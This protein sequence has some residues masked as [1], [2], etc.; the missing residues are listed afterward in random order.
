MRHLLSPPKVMTFSATDPTGGAGLQADILTLASIYCH[1]ISIT[2]AITVQD[3]TGVELVSPVDSQLLKQQAMTIL[4]DVEVAV[5]KLGLLG[6]LENIKAI[7]EILETYPDIPVVLDPIIASGRGDVLMNDSM[8]KAMIRLIF[9]KTTL[10]TPNSIEAR[11]LVCYDNEDFESISISESAKRLFNLGC[12]N[13]LITGGDEKSAAVT[14][15]LYLENG[16]IIPFE[17]ERLIDQY[18]GSGCTLASS[19]AGFCA[20]DYSLKEAVNEAIHFT[21]L[22][23]KNAFNIGHGQLIPD[24]FHWIFN[25]SSYEEDEDG[26]NPTHH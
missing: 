7:S 3:T 18:H 12:K 15:T 2:T 11:K 5:F 9:P 8:K 21:S 14:N 20:Q 25:N 19:I 16:E 4:K 1:P 13:L 6:S 17:S 22:A 23:L 26:D 24:R 10:I